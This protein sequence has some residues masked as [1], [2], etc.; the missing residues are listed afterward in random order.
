MLL[1]HDEFISYIRTNLPPDNKL[2]EAELTSSLEQYWANG[3]TQASFH[4]LPYINNNNISALEAEEGIPRSAC[5]GDS[6]TRKRD[7]MNFQEGNH[8]YKIKNFKTRILELEHPDKPPKAIQMRLQQKAVHVQWPI[9]DTEC[10]RQQSRVNYFTVDNLNKMGEGGG[11]QFEVGKRGITANFHD[12]TLTVLIMR[13]TSKEW[14]KTIQVW[15]ATSI[16]DTRIAMIKTL[17]IINNVTGMNF[18]P[19]A[20]NII[21]SL[22]M[23]ECLDP[24][25]NIQWFGRLHNNMS[26]QTDTVKKTF[27][28]NPKSDC[29][30]GK[31]LAAGEGCS[32]I[33][34][35]IR[36]AALTEVKDRIKFTNLVKINVT[37]YTN[38]KIKL[39]LSTIHAEDE[40]ES[41]LLEF[42]DKDALNLHDF[43]TNLIYSTF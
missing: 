14:P 7:F 33:S 40:D 1:P 18:H 21:S 39:I 29:E 13:C 25:D 27:N 23:V 9:S 43:A 32:H 26:L 36:E 10:D 8:E 22:A 6:A 2:T 42:E 30:N 11:V 35:Q 37:L 3:H 34:M 24:K 19:T 20:M 31:P 41:K 5:K 38:G 17:T 12:T 15:G 28:F 16:N 4:P